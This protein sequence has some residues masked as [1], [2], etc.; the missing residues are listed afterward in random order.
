MRSWPCA[1]G[2]LTSFHLCDLGIFFFFFYFGLPS[3]YGVPWDQGSGPSGNCDLLQ[4][5]S[6]NAGS[7]YPLRGGEGQGRNRTRNL[8]LCARPCT[9]RSPVLTHFIQQWNHYP[10]RK[11]GRARSR[12]CLAPES[13]LFFFF[14]F[15][16]SP[17]T[18]L[19][20]NHQSLLCIYKFSFVIVFRFHI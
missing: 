9:M 5:C 12:V 13:V 6:N 8:V 1:W 16:P 10:F 14:S 4:C 3:A 2:S 11:S 7:F 20:G 19:S 18:S 15:F 17:S